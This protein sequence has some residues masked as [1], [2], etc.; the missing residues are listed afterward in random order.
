MECSASTKV[1]EQF[2]HFSNSS[3]VFRIFVLV[4]KRVFNLPASKS[5]CTVSHCLR[6]MNQLSKLKPNQAKPSTLKKLDAELFDRASEMRGVEGTRRVIGARK[7]GV[8][9]SSINIH[10]E[11][12]VAHYSEIKVESK[13]RTVESVLKNISEKGKLISEKKLVMST[14]DFKNSVKSLLNNKYKNVNYWLLGENWNPI[15]VGKN[16]QNL[17]RDVDIHFTNR[18]GV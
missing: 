13:F 1:H 10:D 9:E 17:A 18:Y 16:C 8:R 12:P 4:L 11:L 7:V 6:I 15:K 5:F 2:T 3:I 14:F